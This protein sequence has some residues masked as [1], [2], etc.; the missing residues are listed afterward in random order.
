MSTIVNSLVDAQKQGVLSLGKLKDSEKQSIKYHKEQPIINLCSR[1]DTAAI[2]SISKESKVRGMLRKI[3]GRTSDTEPWETEVLC[4][5][6]RTCDIDRERTKRIDS[7]EVIRIMEPDTYEKI[8]ELLHEQGKAMQVWFLPGS[9]RVKKEDFES[10]Y[11]K[12][13]IISYQETDESRAIGKKI[14]EIER[15]CLSKYNYMFPEEPGYIGNTLKP[16][17]DAWSE[18]ETRYSDFNHETSVNYYNPESQYTLTD[19]HS[20][21]WRHKTKFNILMTRDQMLKLGTGTQEEKQDLLD[22][23]ESSVKKMKEAERK[24]EGNKFYLRFGIKL[25]DSGNVSY[26]AN[27]SYCADRNGISASSPEKLLEHLMAD[28]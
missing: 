24:Y 8:Q 26:H 6:K 27:Y 4:N 7:D 1:S 13:K 12:N 3:A 22:L 19:V 21:M 5:G 18:L 2:L 14:N 20:N 23:I 10:D 15:E 11:Y 16:F 25:Y 9:P 17:H 28:E